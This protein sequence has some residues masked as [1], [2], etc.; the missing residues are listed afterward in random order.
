[1]G[2]VLRSIAGFAPRRHSNREAFDVRGVQLEP[3]QLGWVTLGTPGSISRHFLFYLRDQT[4]ECDATE[5]AFSVIWKDQPDGAANRSQ[6]IRS[7]PNRTSS[8]S[9]FDR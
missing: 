7:D 9:G 1:M 3:D 5:W 6:P 4:F 8:A 2:T